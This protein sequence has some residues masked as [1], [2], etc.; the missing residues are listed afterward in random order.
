[1][2]YLGILLDSKLYLDQHIQERVTKSLQRLKTIRK[3]TRICR[4]AEPRIIRRLF[5][6]CVTDDTLGKS[7]VGPSCQ[8]FSNQKALDG[9]TRQAGIAIS[10]VLTTVS[11]EAVTQLAH[12]HPLSVLAMWTL[13]IHAVSSTAPAEDFNQPSYGATHL[14]SADFLIAE[15]MRIEESQ[16][17]LD[18][19]GS[20]ETISTL[21]K[22]RVGRR[23]FRQDVAVLWIASL[24]AMAQQ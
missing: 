11:L 2:K 19:N 21:A 8:Y 24:E 10:G 18:R 4:G 9:I 15:L 20:A 17:P 3:L 6:Q 16:V 12:I 22:T 23:R 13:V 1:M 5:L 14:T 7:D